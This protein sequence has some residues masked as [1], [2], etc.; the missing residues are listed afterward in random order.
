MEDEFRADLKK[1]KD[2]GFI[3]PVAGDMDMVEISR[4]IKA[5]VDAA[6]V[7]SMAEQLE[8][9]AQHARERYGDDEG[10]SSE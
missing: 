5:Y 6:L 3:T 8:M 7:G 2:M 1:I 9:Y 4:V 10:G